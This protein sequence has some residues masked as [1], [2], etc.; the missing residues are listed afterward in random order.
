M[1][2]NIIKIGIELIPKSTI[3][4]DTAVFVFFVV[5]VSYACLVLLQYTAVVRCT[6]NGGP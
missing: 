1:S 2:L 5:D 4:F 3:F 6:Y